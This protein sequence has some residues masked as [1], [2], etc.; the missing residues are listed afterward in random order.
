MLRV[1]LSIRKIVS[2]AML[3]LS[4]LAAG[5]AIVVVCMM[6]GYITVKGLTFINLD[7]IISSSVPAGQEGGGLRNEILGTLLLVGLGSFIAVPL[8]MFAG[9][10]LSE[11]GSPKVTSA[12]RFTADVLS[13][14][15][16]IVV[17]VFAYS[18]IVRPMQ[19]FSA[20]SAGAALAIIMIPVVARTTEE[21]MRLVPLS[22]REAALALGITKWRSVVSVT[23]PGA[24]TG[25]VV[26]I[27][28]GIARIAGE[29]AP[30]LFTALGSSF[31]PDGLLNPVGALPMKIYQYALSSDLN[32][33][34]QA[35]AGAFILM[36]LVLTISIAVRFIS[37]RKT[38]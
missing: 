15:P 18:I 38:Q 21:S 2:K 19:S 11:F 22:L 26:G 5:L 10:F 1:S 31:A 23:I 4:T 30:L 34:Q 24:L 20:L 32:W 3:C 12:I 6:L 37:K 35:W 27:M 28:L 8:G 36:L 16:S 25:I 13:G 33:Q 9:V 14:V 7:F 17:G 29:T